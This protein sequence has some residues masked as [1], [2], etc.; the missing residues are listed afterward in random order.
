MGKGEEGK[1]EYL[2]LTN[3]RGTLPYLYSL[4]FFFFFFETRFCS[5]QC[6]GVIIAHDNLDFPGP[7]KP[8]IQPPEWLGPQAPHTANFYSFVFF[9]QGLP[10]LPKL[11]LNSWAQV[12]LLLQPPK[13]LGL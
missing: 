2:P 9:L 4:L 13:V 5:V 1:Y 3:N 10:M 11:V 7:S 8:P 6:R 12:I